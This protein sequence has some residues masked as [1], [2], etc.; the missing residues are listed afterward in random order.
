MTL[1]TKM[2]TEDKTGDSEDK[3]EEKTADAEE[4]KTGDSEEKSGELTDAQENAM[5]GMQKLMGAAK[6]IAMLEPMLEPLRRKL[7]LSME[8]LS[9]EDREKAERVLDHIKALD[10]YARVTTSLMAKLAAAQDGSAADRE[11]AVTG[12]I[13]GVKMLQDKVAEHMRAMKDETQELNE[14]AV[15]VDSAPKKKW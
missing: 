7:T 9:P 11:K 5:Q 4:H 8:H 13:V 6:M 12:L 3:T 1:R 10:A 2:M 14:G 15:L